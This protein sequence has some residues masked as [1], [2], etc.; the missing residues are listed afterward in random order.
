MTT[1][2]QKAPPL[3]EVPYRGIASFRYIDQKIFSAREDETWDLLSSVLIYRGVLLYGD[4]GSGKSS[5]VNAGLMSAASKENLIAHRLRIQPWRGKEIKVERIPIESDDQPPYLPSVFVEEGSAKAKEL[6]LEISLKDFNECLEKLRDAPPNKPH[7]L[8]IFDQ[9]EEFVTLFEEALRGGETPE[10]QLAQREAPEVREAI[11]STLVTLMEDE[12]LPVKVLFVFREE[13]LAKLN[14]LFKVC[15]ELL[16]QYVRLLPPRVEVAEEIIRAPFI[17]EELKTKFT[18]D[19]PGERGEEI[20]EHLAGAIAAQLQQRSENGFIN[21]SELQIICRKLWESSDPVKFFQDKDSDVQ[22]VLEDYWAN[23]LEKLGDLYDPAIALLGHMV[24]S[25]NT[26]NIV[27]EPDLKFHEKGNFTTEQIEKALGAL[28]NRKLVRREPRNK[29]YFY[30]IASEFLVPWIQHK[31]T[32]RLAQIEANKLTIEAEQK[33]KQAERERRILFY[34]AI[35]LGLLLILAV[36]SAFYS[37]NLKKVADEARNKAIEAETTLQTQ[38]DYFANLIKLL[39]QLTNQNTQVRLAAVNE[40]VVLNQN[41]KLPPGLLEVIVSV[42]SNDENEQISKAASPF[43]TSLVAEAEMNPS[44]SDLTDSILKTAQEK[45]T[46]LTNIPPRVYI[47]IASDDQRARADK[48]AAVLRSIGFTVPAYQVVSSNHVPK[49][50]QLRYYKSLDNAET[51]S[52]LNKA[53]NQIKAVDGPNWSP[54]ELKRSSSVRP[55]HFEM[56]FASE[57]TAAPTPTP[58]P[59]AAQ[60]V[61]VKLILKDEQ[62]QDLDS[63]MKVRVSL[64]DVPYSDTTIMDSRSFSAL[65]GN[66]LLF[67]QAPGYELYRQR[68][69][70]QGTEAREYTIVLVESKRKPNK[71][72]VQK[73]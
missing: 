13:Y 7:P 44:G 43:F 69:T 22:K 23:V 8:L 29:I 26:R 72:K 67:V 52:N 11:L 70:L 19:A 2:A 18:G 64:E 10:A 34:G 68:I 61:L 14:L 47:Q 16:D 42:I 4:S 55:G 28:V 15:P 41:G 58:S 53:L 51:S 9:F 24:T 49:T 5:L 40:L 39:N 12:M 33:L 3:P 73:E 27:S 59:T 71:S 31:K 36:S 38:K 35:A 1:L 20:P 62:G 46:A 65:P 50:N 32:A 56:W 54:V 30:E 48:I 6:N 25:S 37:N 57:P 66:Y 45:N 63:S 17:D 21:L 60:K